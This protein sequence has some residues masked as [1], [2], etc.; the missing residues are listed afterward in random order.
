MWIQYDLKSTRDVESKQ[1]PH[2]YDV[3]LDFGSTLTL[4]SFKC[5]NFVSDSAPAK[6]KTL[7]LGIPTSTY[8]Q[9]IVNMNRNKLTVI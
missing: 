3:G 1:N 8:S 6:P 7:T 2:D 4:D 9:I 5:Q